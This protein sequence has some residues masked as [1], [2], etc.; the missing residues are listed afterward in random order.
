MI[1]FNIRI[2]FRLLFFCLLSACTPQTESVFSSL[3]PGEIESLSNTKLTAVASDYNITQSVSAA[4]GMSVTAIVDQLGSA[5]PLEVKSSFNFPTIVSNS[6]S[7]TAGQNQAVYASGVLP[8]ELYNNFSFLTVMQLT[9]GTGQIFIYDTNDTNN[10]ASVTVSGT[11]LVLQHQ[12]SVGNDRTRSYDISSYLNQ[13]HIYSMAFGSEGKDI[14]L[15]VD[16][17]RLTNFFCSF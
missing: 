14:Q 16:G 11:R 9:S 7:F 1:N 15:Y 8:K 10:L 3:R 12:S 6:L 4:S 13:W 2:I 17:F 5:E